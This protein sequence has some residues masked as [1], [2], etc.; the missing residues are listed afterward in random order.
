[1]DE[2]F[3]ERAILYA[4][5]I[6]RVSVGVIGPE[7]FSELEWAAS[8]VAHT[9]AMSPEESLELARVGLPLSDTS[10]WKPATGRCWRDERTTELDR[11]SHPSRELI[12]AISFTSSAQ[13]AGRPA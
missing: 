7:N 13:Y 6:P 12:N 11:Y 3:Y 10:E 4:L 5:S 2:K 9:Q 8:V 1:V